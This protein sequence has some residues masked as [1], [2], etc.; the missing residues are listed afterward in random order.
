MRGRSSRDWAKRWEGKVEKH[1]QTQ[2]RDRQV[3]HMQQFGILSNM[4]VYMDGGWGQG[5]YRDERGGGG[6]SA[7]F[8]IHTGVG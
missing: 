3:N 1:Q 5:C 8:K 2:G 4:G 6:I 7:D